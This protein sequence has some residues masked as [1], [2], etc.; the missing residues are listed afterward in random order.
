MLFQNS[1]KDIHT[2]SIP[3]SC[4]HGSFKFIPRLLE[5]SYSSYFQVLQVN[6]GACWGNNYTRFSQLL[7][8]IYVIYFLLIRQSSK[9]SR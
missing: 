3:N 2:S 9:I 1:N 4:Y 7:S 6:S 8:N 5:L